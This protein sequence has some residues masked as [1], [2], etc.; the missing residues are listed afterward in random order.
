MVDQN[1]LTLF[2]SCLF[3]WNLAL[4]FIGNIL[5]YHFSWWN[6]QAETKHN[7]KWLF[8]YLQYMLKVILVET[9]DSTRDIQIFSLMVSQLSY[10][11]SISHVRQCP[12]NHIIYSVEL[13]FNETEEW[14]T[15]YHVYLHD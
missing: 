5:L 12:N 7:L 1:K 8:V 6:D 11:G 14:Q 9:Q 3:N 15:P 2:Q 10:L 13:G 4:S